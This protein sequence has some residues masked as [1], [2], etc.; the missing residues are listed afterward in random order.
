MPKRRRPTRPGLDALLALLATQ[1]PV[2]EA[3]SQ[4][5]APYDDLSRAEQEDQLAELAA[6]GDTLSA[7]KIAKEL[8][9]YD[10]AQAKAFVDQLRR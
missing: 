6:A 4:S 3:D 7:V 1:F 9:G 2:R 5:H 10:T 8:Y